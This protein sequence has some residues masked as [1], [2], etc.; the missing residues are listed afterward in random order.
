MIQI[1]QYTV[2]NM[3]HRLCS[4]IE[5]AN[6]HVTKIVGIA[7]GGLHV[8]IPLSEMLCLPHQQLRI[9]FYE[10][11]FIFDPQS[12]VHE[13]DDV[14]LLVDDLL[15]S[16]KTID[17]FMKKYLCCQGENLYVACLY[18]KYDNDHFQYANFYV[19]EKPNDWLVF[20]WEKSN[21]SIKTNIF[22]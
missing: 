11:K 21:E 13:S 4:K 10:G 2:D 8:S 16:G 20:P 22:I 14:I 1:D 3:I 15:D 7:N 17:Y 9:S 5:L 6:I 19:E 12:F 18:C